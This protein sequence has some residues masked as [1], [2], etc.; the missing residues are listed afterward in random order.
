MVLYR[1]DF[2]SV[3][4]QG[5]VAGQFLTMF[6][7]GDVL[8]ADAPVEMKGLRV[9]NHVPGVDVLSVD[10]VFQLW[11]A[12]VEILLDLNGFIY[13]ALTVLLATDFHQDAE[14]GISVSLLFKD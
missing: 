8:H 4:I 10:H 3:A 1:S 13:S 11:I 2:Q 5:D 14:G 7:A 12:I 9:L 6:I